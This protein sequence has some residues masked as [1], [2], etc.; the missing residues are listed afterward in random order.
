ML[1]HICVQLGPALPTPPS[2]PNLPART[3][4]GTIFPVGNHRDNTGLG[5]HAITFANCVSRC[6]TRVSVDVH[7]G[8]CIC[9]GDFFYFIFFVE[10]EDQ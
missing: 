7:K 2:L 9:I 4:V 6:Q 8:S 1:N 3:C 5:M 10:I